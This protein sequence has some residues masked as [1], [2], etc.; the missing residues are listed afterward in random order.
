M[1]FPHPCAV[2]HDVGANR[3]LRGQYAAHPSSL[4]EDISNGHTLE[5]L[6]ATLPR[7]FGERHRDIHRVHTP[8]LAHVEAGLDVIHACERK[9]LPYFTR[10]DLVHIDTAV[11]VERRDAPVL[12]EPVPVRGD[13]DEP[14]LRE[15][16]GLSGF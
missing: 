6:H 9:E 1:P 13:F 10:G 2:Y 3:A 11:A 15:P 5:D 4:G 8:I 12:L 16:G 14:A 7:A